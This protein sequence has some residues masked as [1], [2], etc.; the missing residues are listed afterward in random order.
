M[1]TMLGSGESIRESDL[2]FIPERD[3]D[4]AIRSYEEHHPEIEV[5]LDAKRRELSYRYPDTLRRLTTL[6]QDMVSDIE[7][8]DELAFSDHATA[9]MTIISSAT[10]LP[11]VSQ[12]QS[13]KLSVVPGE[14]DHRSAARSSRRFL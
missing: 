2:L 7:R 12:Y 8:R 4:F 6:W 9:A 10:G 1:T 3:R 13:R 14:N 5:G 11:I